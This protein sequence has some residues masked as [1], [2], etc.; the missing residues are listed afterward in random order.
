LE[1]LPVDTSETLGPVGFTTR[2]D[3]APSLAVISLM[4]EVRTVAA[5]LR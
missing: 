5:R 2:A 4:Q 1:L 3:T